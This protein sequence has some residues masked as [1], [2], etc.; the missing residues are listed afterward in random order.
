MAP[1]C[2]GLVQ[3]QRRVLFVFWERKETSP[4][5]TGKEK[6]SLDLDFEP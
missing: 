5:G 3:N 4:K 1:I 6:P 2:L